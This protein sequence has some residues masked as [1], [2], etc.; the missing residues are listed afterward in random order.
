MLLCFLSAGDKGSGS[1]LTA[2]A[3]TEN[4]LM[5]VNFNQTQEINETEV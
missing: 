4:K 2:R 5:E 3:E 1:G